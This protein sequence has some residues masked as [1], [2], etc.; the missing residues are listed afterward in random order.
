MRWKIWLAI[1]VPIFCCI[2]RKVV[3]VGDSKIE[4]RLDAI[5]YL[6][7]GEMYFVRKDIKTDKEERQ[8]FMKKLNETLDTLIINAVVK[9]ANM[10]HMRAFNEVDTNHL[11]KL[12]E[13]VGQ[14]S[15]AIDE[16]SETLIRNRRGLMEEKLARKSKV[17]EFISQMKIMQQNEDNVIKNQKVM[18]QHLSVIIQNQN[19]IMTEHVDLANQ[20]QYIIRKA[21]DLQNATDELKQKTKSL[22]EKVEPQQDE[23]KLCIENLLSTTTTTIASTTAA[24][25]TTTQTII[26]D[27]IVRLV[28][29][30]NQ[31]EGRVEVSYNGR[32]G[33]VCDDEWDDRDARVVCR[34]LG[35]TGGTGYRNA[36]RP[37]IWWY[38]REHREHNFGRG[39]G[40]ILLD[41]VDCRGDEGSL[42][43]CSHLG[44]GVHDCSHSSDAGVRCKP[45]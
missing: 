28:G 17:N 21:S 39:T 18:L 44:I 3:P 23:L 2:V 22:E 30:R 7:R 9:K 19:Q 43:S 40:D 42:F 41:N 37:D 6:V 8:Q 16:I 36:Q 31:Y 45:Y 27:G 13:K 20:L 38:Y 32:Y 15:V 34:M 26:K 12:T 25:T 14:N 5:E 33:T 29:G 24:T 35:Y 10:T 11:E 4:E 1:V